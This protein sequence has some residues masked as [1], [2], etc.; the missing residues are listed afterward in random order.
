VDTKP[1]GKTTAGADGSYSA[2][3]QVSS[4]P[5]G[6][7]RVVAHCGLFIMASDFDVVLATAANPDTSTLLIIIF[8]VLIGLALFRRRIR[9]DAPQNAATGPEEGGEDVS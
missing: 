2:P 1:V 4:L 3:L 8:F 9:L 7:Y 5:V 6:R